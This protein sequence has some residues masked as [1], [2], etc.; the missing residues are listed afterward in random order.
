MAGE[1]LDGISPVFYVYFAVAVLAC[2]YS[3]FLACQ[4]NRYIGFTLMIAL[5][6]VIAFDNIAVAIVIDNL[7][8]LPD[9]LL[10][11]RF[12]LKSEFAKSP[13]KR[14]KAVLQRD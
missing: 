8:N 10:R 5:G 11:T 2:A 13:L 14:S 1:P 6:C 9:D 12:A 4:L 7:S 3:L